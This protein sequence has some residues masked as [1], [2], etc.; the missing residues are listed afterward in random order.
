MIDAVAI[1][2][3][4][5][6]VLASETISISRRTGGSHSQAT[7]RWTSAG[8]VVTSGIAASVQPARGDDLLRLDEGRRNMEAIV[9]CTKTLLQP[10]AKR[11]TV[12]G[13]AVEADRVTWEGVVYEVEHVK[14]WNDRFYDAIAVRVGDQ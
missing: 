1:A 7:G 11:K 12:G 6:D 9:I 2:A 3:Q 8:P 13:D 14:P 5:V 4:A 10:G